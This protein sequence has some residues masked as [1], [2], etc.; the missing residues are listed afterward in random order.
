MFKRYMLKMDNLSDE[1]P[2]Q[3]HDQSCNQ[4]KTE[5]NLNKEGQTWYLV[6]LSV[7]H[8]QEECFTKLLRQVIMLKKFKWW[9]H[10]TI[11]CSCVNQVKIE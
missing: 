10:S 2:Q 7:P 1:D 6:E 3:Y 11:S 5:E 4:V 8:Y 9:I